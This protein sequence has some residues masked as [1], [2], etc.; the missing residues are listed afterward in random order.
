MRFGIEPR[1]VGDIHRHV[2]GPGE[3]E[4]RIPV[5]ECQRVRT[6]AGDRV[7]KPCALGQIGRRVDEGWA[8]I[9]AANMG[10]EGGGEITRRSAEA[11]PDVE[12]LRAAFD[13][14]RLGEFDGRS[15]AARVKLIE[16]RKIGRGKPA[17]GEPGR[18]QCLIKPAREVASFVMLLDCRPAHG[19]PL[20]DLGSPSYAHIRVSGNKPVGS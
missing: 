13:S 4:A 14:S 3:I 19:D 2:L 6:F 15:K 16:R 1:T 18:F 12:H 8:E 11:G 9:D 7:G 5:R 20:V 10:A 17:V